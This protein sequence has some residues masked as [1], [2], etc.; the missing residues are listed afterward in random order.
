MGDGWN[1]D[2]DKTLMSVPDSKCPY[3]DA[4]NA[5][6]ATV[7]VCGAA[8]RRRDMLA[9]KPLAAAPPDGR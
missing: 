9:G 2:N 5:Q 1:N 7:P 6:S 4:W 8:A 3:P